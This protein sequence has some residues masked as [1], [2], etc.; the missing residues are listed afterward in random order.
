MEWSALKPTLCVE[1]DSLSARSSASVLLFTMSIQALQT[2]IKSHICRYQLLDIYFTMWCTF[3]QL[4]LFWWIFDFP[5]LL[6][7]VSH[8]PD[9][10]MALLTESNFRH[11]YWV[12]QTNTEWR[13]RYGPVNDPEPCCP[14]SFLLNWGYKALAC[15]QLSSNNSSTRCSE[16]PEWN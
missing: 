14:P 12:K 1:H 11:F 10:F 6:L 3:I 8:F 5:T 4:T 15:P 7:P 13:P 9:T 2:K 16:D